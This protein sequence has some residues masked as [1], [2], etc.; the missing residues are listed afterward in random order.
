MTIRQPIISEVTYGDNFA[1][2]LI[3]NINNDKEKEKL[4]LDYPTVYIIRDKNDKEQYT[5]YAWC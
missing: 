3:N 1:T 5:V 2:E 4:L